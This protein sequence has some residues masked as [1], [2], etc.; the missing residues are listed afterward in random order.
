MDITKENIDELNAVVKVKVG[1][2]D[3][4]D[5]VEQA[6]KTYQKRASMPGFRPGKV[7]SSLVKKM[8]GKSILA[9]EMNRIL[10][11]SLYKFIQENKLDV[12][13]NPLPKE[14]NNNVDFDN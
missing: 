13:G 3:Y 2:A 12:L 8:Y 11:D 9:E 7:P 10:S 6:L 1:P 4:A 14:E 5:K